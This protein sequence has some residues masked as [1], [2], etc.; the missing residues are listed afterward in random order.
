M[1]APARRLDALP[2]PLTVDLSIAAVRAAFGVALF[3]TPGLVISVLAG[4]EARS[5]GAKL[6]ARAAGVRDIA[7]AVSTVWALDRPADLSRTSR[8]HAVVDATDAAAGVL[9]FKH[10]TPLGRTFA[11]LG[12]S[13]SA[14]VGWL[15]SQRWRER[16][17][18]QGSSA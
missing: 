7:M 17:G 4:G 8:L 1:S 3:A 5:P 12:G 15:Q 10:L 18:P 2:D 13:S 11:L 6:L 16:Y 9:A 14:A